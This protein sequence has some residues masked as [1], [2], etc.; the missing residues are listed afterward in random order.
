MADKSQHRDLLSVTTLEFERD[1]AQV[2]AEIKGPAFREYRKKWD[3]ANVFAYE[4]DF[5][6]HLNLETYFGCIL[7]CVMCPHSL[8]PQQRAA[9]GTSAKRLDADAVRDILDQGRG[10]D[11][12]AVNFGGI[13]EPLVDA[14]L[15]DHIDYAASVGVM[16]IFLCSNAV[17]LDREAAERILHSPVTRLEISL[18][19]LDK[20]TYLSIRCGSDFD[21]VM[22]NIDYFLRRK[23]E[24]GRRLPLVR[25]SAVKLPG[26]KESMTD[27]AAYWQKRVDY[28]AIQ[29]CMLF[30]Q[31]Q[32]FTLPDGSSLAVA[33]P[34][35]APD[36]SFR[37]SQS[38]QLVTI[39][40]N[41]DVAP[42]CGWEGMHLVM[43]NIFDN[44]I[45]DVWNGQKFATFRQNHK[46]E[47]P[48]LHPRCVAC[49]QSIV[50]FHA[51]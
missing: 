22:E 17:L 36:P 37:C 21:K 5:P 19:S 11:L 35:A 39:R 3:A 42:C 38:W 46:M 23:K 6:I 20:D 30:Q 9:W 27:F 7:K 10:T 16:D 34:T 12:A 1:P 47:P 13:N 40:S 2:L 32:T 28:V 49:A 50:D 29:N 45:K 44:S 43:G 41:G 51:P 8:P 25:I 26:N 24:L 15:F 4:P 18:D 14:S 48:R 31:E 33:R